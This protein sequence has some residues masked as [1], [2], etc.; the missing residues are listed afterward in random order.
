LLHKACKLLKKEPANIFYK[1]YPLKFEKS[2]DGF[3]TTDSK[4]IAQELN[5]CMHLQFCHKGST[6]KLLPLSAQTL[7]L[8]TLQNA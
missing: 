1:Q 3:L 2:T 4:T 8:I 7:F 5:R 6:S